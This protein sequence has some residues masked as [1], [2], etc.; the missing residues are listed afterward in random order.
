M[1][2]TAT[3]HVKA[4]N[5]ANILMCKQW[6]R[7][8]WMYGDQEKYYRQ[9]YGRRK[10]QQPFTRINL[11][12]TRPGAQITELTDDF[13]QNHDTITH[14]LDEQQQKI[15]NDNMEYTF[16]IESEPLYAFKEDE[17]TWHKDKRRK[18]IQENMYEDYMTEANLDDI[19]SSGN[20][21]AESIRSMLQ[22]GLPL[23][24]AV[25][26]NRS[27]LEIIDSKEK[28]HKNGHVFGK[29]SRTVCRTRKGA[30]VTEETEIATDGKTT[31]NLKFERST[32]QSVPNKVKE[33]LQPLEENVVLNDCLRRKCVGDRLT[34]TT[35]TLVTV[36]QS[37]VTSCNE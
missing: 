19:W 24:E 14:E 3:Q 11:D 35:R 20:L 29:T 12:D 25:G 23:T 36:T 6:W 7:V 18:P 13:F 4:S 15:N 2:A 31:A 1:S 17:N 21:N 26:K 28:L 33:A 8:C 32:V 30:I 9:L 37:S 27:P 5:S 34:T 10:V 22:N 16:S